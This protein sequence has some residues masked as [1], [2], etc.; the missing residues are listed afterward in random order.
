MKVVKIIFA[1]WYVM[2][3]WMGW[4]LLHVIPGGAFF[5]DNKVCRWLMAVFALEFA[6]AVQFYHLYW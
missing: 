5:F 3:G 6:S 1:I 4:L 2:I